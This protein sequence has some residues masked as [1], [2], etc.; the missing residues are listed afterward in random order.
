[1]ATYLTTFL[2][3]LCYKLQLVLLRFISRFLPYPFMLHVAMLLRFYMF[4][5]YPFMLP[6]AILKNLPLLATQTLS[7]PTNRRLVAP[8]QN[9]IHRPRDHFWCHWKQP[10][11]LALCLQNDCLAFHLNH[12]VWEYCCVFFVPLDALCCHVTL[13]DGNTWDVNYTPSTSGNH[14][15]STVNTAYQPFDN[16]TFI[17]HYDPHINWTW[18]KVCSNRLK[19]A[20]W[21]GFYEEITMSL[22]N[23]NS[24][25]FTI[26][27]LLLLLDNCWI[28]SHCLN[29][30]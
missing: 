3:H 4:L 11:F 14:N 8:R 24:W 25:W 1:M 7:S 5:P 15:L 12:S 23:K 21:Q 19:L 22:A 30:C 29:H 16:L 17:R 18:S 27:F 13:G 20:G 6:V 10:S 9:E 26:I 2:V 28:S